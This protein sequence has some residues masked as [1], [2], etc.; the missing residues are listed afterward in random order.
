MK[1]IVNPWCISLWKLKIDLRMKLSLFFFFFIMLTMHANSTYSQKTKVSLDMDNA[2]ISEIIDEIEANTEFKFLFNTK[3]VDLNRR[4]S[5]KIKKEHIDEVLKKIFLN[6][7]T[8]FEIKDRKIL[9]KVAQPNEKRTLKQSA[10]TDPVQQLVSG[11]ITDKEGRPLLGASI[12]IE[13]S[14]IG[15]TTDFDGYYTLNITDDTAVLVVSYLGFVTKRVPVNGQD[16]IDVELTEDTSVLE[17]VIVVGYGSQSKARVTG[18]IT[19]LKAEEIQNVP[20]GG[21][22]ETIAGQASGVQ[23]T[24]G[25]GAPGKNTQINIRGVGSLTAGTNPLIVVDGF[26][27]TE[28][29]SLSSI[30][31]NDI[32]SIDI[33]KDAASAAIYGS[34]GASGVIMVSTKK[35]KPND[36]VKI[37][38]DVYTGFQKPS[39]EVDVLGAYDYAQLIKEARDRAYV[40][41]NP[42]VNLATDNNSIRTSRYPSNRR[43]LIPEYLTPYL[44]KESGL[45]DTNW[46]DE[47]FRTA[48]ISSYNLSVSGGSEKTSYFVSGSYFDQQGIILGSDYE[49]MSARFNIESKLNDRVKFGVNL[50]PTYATTNKIIED[51]ADGPLQQAIISYPFFAPYN[52]DGSYNISGQIRANTL[53]DASLAENPVAI[54]K[55]I[56]NRDNEFRLYGNTFLELELLSDLKFKTLLGGDYTSFNNTYFRPSFIGAYR[57]EAPSVT[58]GSEASLVNKNWLV[59]TTL[60]YDKS[61]NDHN[62]KLLAGYSFQKEKT[63]LTT[64]TGSDFPN[65]LITNIEGA[66]S[67]S[68]TKKID[69]W[70][71]LSYFGRLQYN[72]LD[73]YLI[74]ASL[75]RDGSSRF[76]KES[77][78]GVFPAASVGWVISRE[79]FFPEEDFAISNLKLR[80]SWGE[81]GNNQIGNYGAIPLFKETNSILGN[82]LVGGLST[83]TSPNPNLSWETT[84]TTNYGLNMGFFD[85]VLNLAADYYIADTKDLL[86]EV[87]V[88]SQ[89]GFSTSIQN[90]GKVRNKGIEIELNTSDINLGPVKWKIGV[91]Y[92][93]SDNEVIEIAPGRT[94]IISGGDGGSH[95][96]Q[97]GSPIGSFYGYNVLG[98]YKDQAAIDSNPSFDGSRVGDFIIEDSNRDGV[99]DTNDKHIIGDNIPDFTYGISTRFA[100]NNFDLSFLFN[101]VQGVS[102]YDRSLF[103]TLLSNESFSNASQ[104]AFDNRFHPTNNPN[105]SFP[106]PDAN[107]SNNRKAARTSTFFLED[108]SYFR[109]RN[110]TLGYS[111]SERL[112][113][114]IGFSKFR[115]YATAKNPVIWTKFRGFNPEQTSGNPLTP[116]Y[117]LGNYPSEK[118]MVFGVNM[119]F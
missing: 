1:K 13:G 118:S 32:E 113:K 112:L 65:D 40:N 108:A 20:V 48:P 109:I 22:D 95:I 50:S 34:R 8:S 86:L 114:N 90:I 60:S 67:T 3:A 68:A 56:T 39:L 6:T 5:L 111:F 14:S 116:G 78:Y 87:P 99:V 97:V 18:S 41:L 119:S 58:R 57:D 38:L 62:L 74:S 23:I 73:K 33:L 47:I 75:R 85:D 81:T 106:Q 96:T 82:E 15:T 100:Y 55:E 28:G 24:E 44:N 12:V 80:F 98:I 19:S 117:T 70:A 107:L 93:K 72:Y 84:I 79:E 83:S 17:D 31:P 36:G 4:I 66:N 27:L 76:G 110:I 63:S 10:N 7:K 9:L 30:N 21:F 69:E 92:T 77:K 91:N 59:E 25:S 2:T 104:E 11:K 105:G 101:G 71:L 94:E 53:S 45:T 103:L 26:P 51:W 52:A 89:S 102:V 64:T 115:I 54:A 46:L 37:N 42:T 29:S 49:R 35:G 61:F 88:P 16:L 43:I